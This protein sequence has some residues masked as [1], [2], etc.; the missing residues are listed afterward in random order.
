MDFI[1]HLPLSQG[2]TAIWVIV[3]RLTKFGHFIPLPPHYSAPFLA[4]LFSKEIFR[5]HDAP[6]S[7]VSYRDAIFL[8]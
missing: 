3:D 1:T 6:K 4:Q 5:L 2:H 7:I 8:S